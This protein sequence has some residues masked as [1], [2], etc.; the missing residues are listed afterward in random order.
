MTIML[1][2]NEIK[3]INA[4]KIKKYR[5]KYDEFI[6]EGKKVIQELIQNGFNCKKIYLSESNLHTFDFLNN[7]EHKTISEAEFKKISNQ[8]SPSNSL[9]IFEK[10]KYHLPDKIDNWIIALDDIQDPGNLGTIIRIADWF[11]IETIVCSDNCVDAFNS[12]TI[13]ASMAS[14]ANVKIIETDLESF[15]KNN[16]SISVFGATLHGENYNTINFPQKGILLIGNEGKGINQT[17]YPFI[18]QAITIPKLGKA[19]SLNA[20]IATSLLIA[21]IK[22]I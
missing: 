21:K 18:H 2:S 22:L 11:G 4:L 12:K 9:A 20:A 3:H 6:A 14:I 7:T 1:S 13:Q 10:P 16:A 5:N 19:E 15:F 8:K 17:L